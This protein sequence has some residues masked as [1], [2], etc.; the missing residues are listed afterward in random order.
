MATVTEKE[1]QLEKK[2]IYLISTNQNNVALSAL[3]CKELLT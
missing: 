1:E 3:A 2:R